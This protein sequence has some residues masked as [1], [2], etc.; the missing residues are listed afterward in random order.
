M[1]QSASPNMMLSHSPSTSPKKT[2]RINDQ[3]QDL[4]QVHAARMSHKLRRIKR[5]LLLDA[6]ANDPTN[7]GYAGSISLAST[8]DS[9]S[10]GERVFH[11]ARYHRTLG[12][13]MGMESSVSCA[14]SVYSD[15][16]ESENLHDIRHALV[17]RRDDLESCLE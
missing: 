16:T 12:S 2:V 14:S 17:Q 6:M 7:I 15:L 8:Q 4:R 1:L 11:C 3:P 9:S 5:R 13:A 10:S